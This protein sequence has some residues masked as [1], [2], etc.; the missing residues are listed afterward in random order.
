A[1][2]GHDQ[3]DPSWGSA[4]AGDDDLEH[5]PV[6]GRQY[7]IGEILA[8]LLQVEVADQPGDPCLLVVVAAMVLIGGR[9]D[10]LAALSLGGALFGR[11]D[12]VVVVQEASDPSVAGQ[13][14]SG[15]G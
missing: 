15:R 8:G 10:R 3:G 1:V 13:P 4:G 11:K 6:D 7:V 2:D 12:Q 9:M 5:G 14:Q